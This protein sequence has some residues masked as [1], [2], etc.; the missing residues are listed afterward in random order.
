MFHPAVCPLT[1]FFGFTRLKRNGFRVGFCHHYCINIGLL[2][3]RNTPQV[4]ITSGKYLESISSL[5]TLSKITEKVI[6][7]CFFLLLQKEPAQALNVLAL[8]ID[9]ML[10]IAHPLMFRP[11][12]VLS[13]LTTNISAPQ[14]MDPEVIEKL[15]LNSLCKLS[16][17]TFS[18]QIFM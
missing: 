18:L 15:V 11:P 16:D 6:L 2:I 10:K 1:I 7:K 14:M 12:Y 9:T 4:P 5:F 8:P 13:W 17:L 3:V